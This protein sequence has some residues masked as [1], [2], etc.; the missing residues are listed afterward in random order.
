MNEPRHRVIGERDFPRNAFSVVAFTVIELMVATAV[1]SLLLL[2]LLQIVGGAFQS[3]KTVASQ[4]DS[5]QVARRAID[6]LS[7]DL[8][9]RVAGNGACV[10]VNENLNLAFITQGRGPAMTGTGNRFL[11]VSYKFETNSIIRS[12]YPVG[13]DSQTLPECAVNATTSSA[14]PSVL[15]TGILSWAVMAVME[16]GSSVPLPAGLSSHTNGFVQGVC[17]SGALTGITVPM[18]WKAINPV[19][20]PTPSTLNPATA[21][22]RSLQITLAA[23]DGMNFK[24]LEKTGKLKSLSDAL[25][26][27]SANQSVSTQWNDAINSQ[28]S[29]PEPV[30][31]GIRIL[32]GSIDLQ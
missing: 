30:R 15:A 4:I 28:T 27:P 21:R 8:K 5:C 3:S 32:T 17:S 1:L 24:I 26:T 2:I 16:D 10:L 19:V 14:S 23:V 22:V 31:S 9:N 18:K 7:N 20:A 29:L 13:W 11:A 6:S 25:A 12:Y